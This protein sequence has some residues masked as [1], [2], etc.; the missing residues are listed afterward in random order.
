MPSMLRAIKVLLKCLI[1][2]HLYDLVVQDFVFLR[3]VLHKSL[4]HFDSWFCPDRYV[5]LSVHRDA[6][7]R[8]QQGYLCMSSTHGTCRSCNSPL[9]VFKVLRNGVATACRSKLHRLLAFLSC[10][11]P[12]EDIEAVAKALSVRNYTLDRRGE[13]W[14]ESC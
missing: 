14:L 7:S 5:C 11:K 2:C 1:F 10:C 4:L 9:R 12:N 3:K 6:L 13:S 8:V